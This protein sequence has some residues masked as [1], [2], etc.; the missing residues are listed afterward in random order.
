M[1]EKIEKALERV[2]AWIDWS[3]LELN[4]CGFRAEDIEALAEI[5]EALEDYEKVEGELADMKK[6]TWCAYCGY[7]IL[8]DDN[9]A[10]LIGEHIRTCEKHPIRKLE[11][12]LEKQ[13]PLIEAVM[14]SNSEWVLIELKELSRI[15]T[16]DTPT[17]RILRAALAYKEQHEA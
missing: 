9:A 10:S 14:E 5:R 1:N 3:Q 15:R 12:E 13:R 17:M 2:R 7:E 16:S 6:H 11:V 8:I 4:P